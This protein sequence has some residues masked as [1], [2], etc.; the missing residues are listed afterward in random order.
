MYRDFVWLRGLAFDMSGGRKPR[1]WLEDARS[2]E[3]SGLGC[4]PTV[5][6]FEGLAHDQHASARLLSDPSALAAKVSPMPGAPVLERTVAFSFGGSELSVDLLEW[7]HGNG[8]C[9]DDTDRLAGPSLNDAEGARRRR[10]LAVR[11]VR[12]QKASCS[13]LGSGDHKGR[14]LVCQRLIVSEVERLIEPG[15]HIAAG[16]RLEPSPERARSWR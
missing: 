15:R 10:W 8:H 12:R 6:D 14:Q 1:S 13:P 2:M 11:F 3:G 5:D 9:L 16:H 4:E 7:E